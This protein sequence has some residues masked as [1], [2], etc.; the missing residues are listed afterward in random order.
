MQRSVFFLTLFL[1]FYFSVSAQ[2]DSFQEDIIGYLRIN[3]TYQQY[4][5][6][7]DQMYTVL[8]P[9]WESANVP[10]EVWED[11]KKNREE[12]GQRQ[13]GIGSAGWVIPA[14]I[15]GPACQTAGQLHPEYAYHPG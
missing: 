12:K 7:Y 9:Q 8:A 10:E 13:V 6:A 4:D 5:Q 3:G 14:E 1:S 11:L 2:I 15:H